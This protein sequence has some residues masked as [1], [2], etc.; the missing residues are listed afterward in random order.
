MSDQE[1]ITILLYYTD[2]L[3]GH[4]SVSR[5]TLSPQDDGTWIAAVGR[6]W[7]VGTH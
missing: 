7:G 4:P 2:H 5:F 3:G 6:H 1:L